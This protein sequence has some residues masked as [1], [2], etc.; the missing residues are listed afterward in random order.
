MPAIV[1][2]ADEARLLA[3]SARRNKVIYEDVKRAL[4]ELVR[5]S[6]DAK[7]RA[8]SPPG[9]ARAMPLKAG[10]K[11]AETPLQR[12]G[13]AADRM[14]GGEDLSAGKFDGRN[15]LSRSEPAMPA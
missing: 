1:D 15:G 14:S 9:S 3:S 11:S 5:P 7:E 12:S 2:T 10:R 6:D 8:F 13:K 4:N